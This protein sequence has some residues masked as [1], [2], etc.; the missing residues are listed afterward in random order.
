MTC[1]KGADT[2]KGEAGKARGSR[3]ECRP[4]SL[5]YHGMKDDDALGPKVV[6]ESGQAIVEG[7]N[8]GYVDD[9]ELG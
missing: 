9:E 8:G 5:K 6:I 2:G 7:I 1:A 4:Q 3:R